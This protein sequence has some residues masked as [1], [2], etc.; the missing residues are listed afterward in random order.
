[1]GG[2]RRSE[3]IVLEVLR[4]LS[5]MMIFRTFVTRGFLGLGVTS[6]IKRGKLN[7][8]WIEFWV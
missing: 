4:F 2:S 6:G 7:I 8:D 5:E 1:M 3:G